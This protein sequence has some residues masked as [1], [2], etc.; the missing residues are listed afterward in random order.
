MTAEVQSMRG[1]G[2]SPMIVIKQVLDDHDIDD[3]FEQAVLSNA[4]YHEV[5]GNDLEP[6]DVPK[7]PQ[8][9]LD[10]MMDWAHIL[11]DRGIPSKEGRKPFL[12]AIDATLRHFQIPFNDERWHI[13]S[14]MCSDFG[15][16]SGSRRR[17]TARKRFIEAIQSTL[18][19][20]PLSA[21]R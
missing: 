10:L 15:T 14:R 13:R 4:I 1:S 18:P 17:K 2:M 12:C 11:Y 8:K 6:S 20:D 3:P 7:N 16:H 19:F 5:T 9:L 21:P